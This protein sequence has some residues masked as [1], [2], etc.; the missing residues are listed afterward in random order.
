MDQEGENINIGFQPVPPKLVAINSHQVEAG[1][2]QLASP[3][4]S[5]NLVLNQA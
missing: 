5:K 2:I 3:K 4:L 1:P